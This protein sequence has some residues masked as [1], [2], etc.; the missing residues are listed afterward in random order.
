M[1]EIVLIVAAHPDDEVLGVGGTAAR[2]ADVGDDVH[3]LIMAEG[4]TSRAP[5]R[6]Q[7][8]HVLELSA[9]QRAANAAAA[10]LGTRPP[11]FAALPDNR[12]DSLDLLD[13]VKEVEGVIA[14]LRPAIVYTHHG[15]DLNIDHVVTH[16]ATLTA[17][18]PLPGQTVRALYTFETVSSSEWG[19][20]DQDAP[21][22]P[23]H[24]VDI[25][26]ALDRKMAALRCYEAEMRPFPHAR[27]HQAVEAL[28]RLRGAQ[29]GLIAAEGFGVI[30]SFWR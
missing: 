29:T 10:I 2:H 7:E 27:S 9:L 1:S 19:S 11:I 12:L 13:V 30:R 15:G 17:C 21:F 23:L 20:S 28:T 4:A 5:Q 8:E 25:G 3:V 14:S 24:F 6:R 22:R 26:P 16:R 18:R